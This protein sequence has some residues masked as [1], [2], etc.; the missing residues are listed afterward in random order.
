MMESVESNSCE[1]QTLRRRASSTRKRPVQLVVVEGNI[2]AGKS[3]LCRGLAKARGYTVFLEPTAANPYLELYYKE[4]KKYAL[5]LQMWML[6][7]RFMSYLE[8][9]KLAWSE[10]ESGDQVN[11]IL[12]D[13]SIFSDW[14]FAKKN[15][16]DGNITKEG[17][18]HYMNVRN[19]MLERIPLPDVMINLNVSPEECYRRVHYG[20]QR[21]YESGIPLEYLQGLTDCYNELAADLERRNVRV[22]DLK[23]DAFVE[24]EA[25]SD[26]LSTCIAERCEQQ[27]AGVATCTPDMKQGVLA[28]LENR[29]AFLKQAQGNA[30]NHAHLE[31]DMTKI[32]D[33]EHQLNETESQHNSPHTP[34]STTAT[35]STTSSPDIETP[36]AS[37]KGRSK[38]IY[39]PTT[40]IAP[41][42]ELTATPENEKVS[43]SQTTTEAVAVQ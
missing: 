14:V 43:A 38:Q 20:R 28:M 10:D 16:D 13:R 23:S 6:E 33:I 7:H 3:T 29:P 22:L 25:V 12:L 30:G 34:T 8:A 21:N 24:C 9:L 5:P 41:M 11:G 36:A 26:R 32:Q 1:R 2:S 39:S 15:F 18:D 4:P 37:G 27:A 31:M 40:I 17:Y 35:S 42:S 19:Q